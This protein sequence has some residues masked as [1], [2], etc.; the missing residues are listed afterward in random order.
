MIKRYTHCRVCSGALQSV[1]NLG[2]LHLVG[3]IPPD[4]PPPPQYPLHLMTCSACGLVQL[5]HSVNPDEMYSEYWYRS[6]T[7][8]Q[9]VAHLKTIPKAASQYVALQPS[10]V[11]LDI[12]CNDGTLLSGYTGGVIRLG[13]DPSNIRPSLTSCDFF[14]NEYFSAAA[15]PFKERAKVITSIAMFYDL[16]DP[17]QFA[18]DVKAVLHPDGVWILELHYLPDM[19][20]NNGFDA[21]CHEHVT[22]YN[23]KTLCH[24][25]D[26]AQLRVVGYERN[27]VN[28]GSFR[29]YVKHGPSTWPENHVLGNVSIAEAIIRTDRETASFTDFRATVELNKHRMLALLADLRSEGKLVLGYGAS[30]KGATMLQYWGLT[31]DLLPAIADRNP[32]K[33]GLTVAGIPIISE[34]AMRAMQPDYLLVLPYH[35]MDSF[36]KREHEFLASGGAFIIPVP[37]PHI[38]RWG[39]DA[40]ESALRIAQGEF[41]A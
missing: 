19:L 26:V 8:E 5:E 16:D 30:T 29:V 27:S 3:F 23:M 25:L 37:T 39:D 13:F 15:Y 41:G 12:G 22:Y 18:R 35:F 28:G 10:D 14:I 2:D 6:G 17:V 38:Y 4:S 21:I 24:V 32:A 1:L 34:A 7:N 36:K 31:P 40:K 33:V 20:N 9:M 11:V